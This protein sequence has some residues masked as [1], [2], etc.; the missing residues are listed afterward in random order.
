MPSNKLNNFQFLGLYVQTRCLPYWFFGNNW[1]LVW[2]LFDFFA[3]LFSTHVILFHL[4]HH[5][6]FKKD[7]NFPL[8]FFLFV[9][10]LL[11]IFFLFCF[12]WWHLF[13]F[14]S[15][16]QSTKNNTKQK[17]WLGVFH[18]LEKKRI[19]T[20][21]DSFLTVYVDQLG[22]TISRT[23]SVGRCDTS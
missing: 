15:S 12:T 22:F 6:F 3:K 19:A 1:F 5:F 18:Y 23:E 8:S 16:N 11:K 7:K 13:Y 17:K 4:S 20:W 2:S 9:R 10:R 21:W 14:F